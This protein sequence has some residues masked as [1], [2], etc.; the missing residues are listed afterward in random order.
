MSLTRLA[1]LRRSA[2]TVSRSWACADDVL[3]PDADWLSSTRHYHTQHPSTPLTTPAC[4]NDLPR[5][6][7]SPNCSR[8]E[9]V[10]MMLCEFHRYFN[11]LKT[12]SK[13]RK[14]RQEG[15]ATPAGCVETL[16]FLLP[17]RRMCNRRRLSVCLS[18]YY[19]LCAK[20]SK[21]SCMIFSGKVGNGPMNK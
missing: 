7:E 1:S 20:T 18:V 14:Q 5:W 3:L 4:H 2:I 9:T 11:H 21:R 6:R 10:I 8:V 19:Q 15:A 17:L 16:T 13:N 12:P